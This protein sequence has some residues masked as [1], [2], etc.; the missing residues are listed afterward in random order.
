MQYDYKCLICHE[1]E[2]HQ[3][4]FDIDYKF[5]ICNPHTLCFKK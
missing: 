3:E 1:H 4:N 2:F 5:N